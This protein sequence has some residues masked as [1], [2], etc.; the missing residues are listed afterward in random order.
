MKD[1]K[2]LRFID[3]FRG[4]FESFGVDYDTMRKILQVKFLLDERRV[5]TVMKNNSSKKKSEEGNSIVKSLWFYILL[6]LIL[7]PF[8]ILEGNYLFKMSFLFGI[9]MF[10]MM[11]FR[12]FFVPIE[13]LF[14]VC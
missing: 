3:K 1:F 11:L 13:R 7:V 6:G 14:I 12:T 8:V 5:P 4:L 10:M 9:L 2:I